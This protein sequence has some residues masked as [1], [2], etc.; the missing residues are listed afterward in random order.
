MK[1]YDEIRACRFCN[2][3]LTRERS[4]LFG[5]HP[6]PN[7]LYTTQ[8]E[9]LKAD[10][11]PIRVFVCARCHAAQLGHTVDPEVMFRNYYYRSG[12]SGSYK[13]H[14]KLLYKIFEE[15]TKKSSWRTG[16][17][18][19]PIFLDI[20]GNDGTLLSVFKKEWMKSSDL[21]P[22]LINVDPA[23]SFEQHNEKLGIIQKFDY[24]GFR[25]AAQL[26]VP[27]VITATNVFAHVDD[28]EGFLLACKMVMN[29]DTVLIIEFPYYPNLLLENQIDT[30]YTEHLSYLSLSPV[31]R[32]I[33]KVG[34]KLLNVTQT[35]IHGGSVA[36]TIGKSGAYPVNQASFAKLLY[37][38]MFSYSVESLRN[39]RAAYDSNLL[40]LKSIIKDYKRPIG[41]GAGAKATMTISHMGKEYDGLSYVID[42][43]PEKADKY[44][45][46]TPI[47]IKSRDFIDKYDP[48]LIVILQ[49]NVAQEIIKSLPG[50]K[51]K[52]AYLSV[53][54]G[55]KVV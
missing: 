19:A 2:H 35:P 44:I 55:V 51:G 46:C 5:Y 3:E 16:T 18:L 33:E 52:F 37:D 48:D 47:Q 41:F 1:Q 14:C 10:R 49:W 17:A 24:W 43:T 8:R 12:I 29:Y 53:E 39:A 42:D 54:E 13:E 9:S 23:L 31:I 26:G 15:Q 6:L 21:Q 27:A 30:I 45:P 25:A 11:Y 40:L 22:L 4:V 36:L 32:L 20:A 28:P 34:L 38:E 7:N 50:Y